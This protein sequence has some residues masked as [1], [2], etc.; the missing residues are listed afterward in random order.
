MSASTPARRTWRVSRVT[1]TA[2][3]RFS[4]SSTPAVSS[5]TGDGA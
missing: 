1:S 2:R 4:G 3:H 5:A